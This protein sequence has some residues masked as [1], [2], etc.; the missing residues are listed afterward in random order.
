MSN[1]A[2]DKSVTEHLYENRIIYLSGDIT[3]QTADYVVSRLLVLD[4]LD[5]ESEIRLY[6][7]SYG[8]SVY[9]GLAIYDAMQLVSAPISTFCIGPAFSM[10]AWLLAAGEPGRRFATP[11]SRI[12]IHQT[13]AGF[14]G[15]SADI[16]VAAENVI[17]SERLMNEL[18]A[19]HTK[20]GLAEIES[21]VQ[22]DL[23]MT[24]QEAMR[25]GMI[26]AIAPVATRKSAPPSARNGRSTSDP[27]RD[28]AELNVRTL[29]DDPAPP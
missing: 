7:S 1:D 3:T 5:P 21:A 4:T 20:R 17:K 13:S 18:L 28:R 24:P 10:A 14:L 6:L 22:R 29:E 25:F 11:N 2:Y 26:D 15:T 12:M 27:R 23:W 8:G 9:A 16:K 19:R